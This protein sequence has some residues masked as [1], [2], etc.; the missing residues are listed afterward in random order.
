M[1]QKLTDEQVTKIKNLLIDAIKYIIPC[2]YFASCG[3]VHEIKGLDIR[4]YATNDLTTYYVSVGVG[5][6]TVEVVSLMM[7]HDLSEYVCLGIFCLNIAIVCN[8]F[9]TLFG[10]D[11]E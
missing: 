9:Y 4:A 1:T 7:K 5:A 8:M 11:D 10:E 6:V 2:N 3:I